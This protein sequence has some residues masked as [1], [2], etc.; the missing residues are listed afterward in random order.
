M[1]RFNYLRNNMTYT[2]EDEGI[3]SAFKLKEIL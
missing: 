1:F 2:C 3:I